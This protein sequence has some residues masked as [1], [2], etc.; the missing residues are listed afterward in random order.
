[1]DVNDDDIIGVDDLLGFL[2]MFGQTC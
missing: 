2:S 1:L